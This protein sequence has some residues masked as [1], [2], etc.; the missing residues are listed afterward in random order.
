M[1]LIIR[2]TVFSRLF[3][4]IA[5]EEAEV[6]QFEVGDDEEGHEGEGHEGAARGEPRSF[7]E[8]VDGG[9]GVGD[10]IAVVQAHEAGDGEGK[11]Q[12]GGW[13]RSPVMSRGGGCICGVLA[14]AVGRGRR[15]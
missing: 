14:A 2:N 5:V 12:S 8:V 4:G 10:V 15:S 9:V 7:G 6:A 1:K 13:R 11:D 3:K